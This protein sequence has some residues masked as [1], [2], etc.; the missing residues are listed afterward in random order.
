VAGK[1]PW[2]KHLAVELV[3]QLEIVTV[4]DPSLAEYVK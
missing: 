1:L 3:R 2:K 4:R